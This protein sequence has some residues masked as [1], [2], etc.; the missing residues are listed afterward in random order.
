MGATLFQ[1]KSPLARMN[2]Y[3]DGFHFYFDDMGH[4][5]EAHHYCAQLTEDFI[6]CVIYDGNTPE[7]RL[8]GIEYIVSE[9]LFRTLAP[10]ERMLWHSHHYEVKSGSLVAPGIPEGAEHELM[11]KT[12]S[13]YGKTWHTW[14]SHHHDLPVGIPKLMAGFTGDG[15]LNPV[16]LQERDRLLR[17]STA[18]KRINRQDI[19]E[20]ALVDGANAWESGRRLQLT[21]HD[22]AQGQSHAG[23]MSP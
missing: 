6:Q 9:R 17:I 13:T 14:D 21:L 4:Q 7:A 11:R 18:R 16:L 15:Q 19:D 5:V 23:P 3:L 20:P 10:E 2:L 1:S 22:S 12:V 8:I